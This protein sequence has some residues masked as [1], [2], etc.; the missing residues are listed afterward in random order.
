MNIPRGLCLVSCWWLAASCAVGPDYHRPSTPVPA[1]FR[2]AFQPG[3]PADD[4]PRGNWWEAYGDATLDDLEAKA[5]QANQTIAAADAQYRAALAAQAGSRAG[6]YPTIGAGASS[7][8][9][10][11]ST[12]T[13]AGASGPGTTTVGRDRYTVDRVTGSATWELDLWGRLRRQLESSRAAA[14][15]SRGDL[16]AAR[17]SVQATLAQNYFQ[18]RALDM[19]RETLTRTMDGYRRSLQITRNRYAAGVAPRTDVT[20]AESTLASAEA[21]DADLA[22]QRAVLSHGIAVLTGRAPEDLEVPVV[23]SLPTMPEVPA[24]LPATILERR[25]DVAAAERRVASANAAIGLAESAY[26]PTLSLSAA[27]GYQGSTWQHLISAPHRY[28]SFGP[29]LAATLFDGGAR[30]A[31][32]RSADA[33][34]DRTVAQYRQTVLTAIADVD[35]ALA[36]LK[37]LAEEEQASRRAAAAAAETLRATENQYRAGTVSYLNVVIAESTSLAADRT[38]IDVRS[39]RLLAHVALL[40]AAGGTPAPGH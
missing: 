3:A 35:D 16:E 27:G 32:V 2:E 28:W 10:A 20:E 38:L 26:F 15:A 33:S 37:G 19:Q 14:E 1:A 17:L 36:S 25:P 31:G 23:A 9:N 5:G 6:F 29:Q 22:L 18:L 40:K 21:Q 24:V 7:S 30:I 34:Y 8:R 11:G 13:T 12:T 4:L 39:R